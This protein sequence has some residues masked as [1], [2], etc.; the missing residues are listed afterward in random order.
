M[1]KTCEQHHRYPRAT[2]FWATPGGP[3]KRSTKVHF[4][5]NK[6][7][8]ACGAKLGPN[9]KFQW[10]SNG[11]YKEYCECK[12]CKKKADLPPYNIS[13]CAVT[14]ALRATVMAEIAGWNTAIDEA[15]RSYRYMGIVNSMRNI[16]AY[17]HGR[18]TFDEL[19]SWSKRMVRNSRGK[20]CCPAI[21]RKRIEEKKDD[22]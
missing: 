3:A 15:R 17:L 16:Q 22:R 4:T 7:L 5:N 14:M 9:Q 13:D 21:K 1:K 20:D 10:C 2:G 8:P 6:G 19:D 11:W 18:L 12:N